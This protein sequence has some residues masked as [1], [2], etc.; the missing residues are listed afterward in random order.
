M[1]I[2][3]RPVLGTKLGKGMKIAIELDD[4]AIAT[5]AAVAISELSHDAK[6]I[7]LYA[8]LYAIAE[9]RPHLAM[10]RNALRAELVKA[11]LRRTD[12]YARARVAAVT[13]AEGDEADVADELAALEEI[14]KAVFDIDAAMEK[15][16]VHAAEIDAVM[17]VT[18]D[19]KTPGE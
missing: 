5:L 9:F 4:D 19:E 17:P 16:A 6:H 12:A 2:T 14:V 10:A 7:D 15:A 18:P 3:K 13:D 1:R 8:Q 11:V